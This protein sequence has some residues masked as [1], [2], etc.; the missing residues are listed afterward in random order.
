[1]DD[2]RPVDAPHPDPRTDVVDDPICASA[3]RLPFFLC[4]ALGTQS[5]PTNQT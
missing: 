5:T 3:Y 4:Q 2:S 1:M